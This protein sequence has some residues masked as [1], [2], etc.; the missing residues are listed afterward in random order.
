MAGSGSLEQTPTWAVATVCF[1]LI[2]ISIFIEQIIHMIG[3]WFK[4]KRKKA[5][6]EALEKIKA[7]LMLLGFIS[8]LLTVGTTP[9]TKICISE[10]AASGWHPC[11]RNEDVAADDGGE[12]RRRLL[13]WSKMGNNARRILAGA[14]SGGDDKCAKKGKVSFMSYDGVHQLHIF[15]FALALFHVIYSVLTMALGQAKMRKWKN[16]EKETRTIEYQFSHD[17]ERFRFARDT[18]FGRRHMSFWSKSPILLWIVCFFRQFFRSVPKVDYLT[19]RHGFIMAHLGPQNQ[20]T[21]DFQK[22]I[23][24]SLEND[25][26]TVVGISPPIWLFAIVFLLFNTHGWYSYLW[27]PF[28]PLVVILLIGTKLQVII[29][30]MGLSIQERGEVVQGVPVVQTGDDL[31]WFNRPRLILYLIN[32]VLFQNAFQVAFFAWTWYEFGIKSCFH[33]RTEDV[34]I[35]ITMG[36]LVQILCSYVTLP[37][38]ALV[39]QMGSNMRPTVFNE[40]VATAIRSWHKTAKKQI[41][42]NQKSGQVTPMSSRPG[43]PTH[44]MSPVHLL[45]NYRND[46][47]SSQT[48]PRMSNFDT[49]NWDTD[50][51]PS[52]SYHQRRD[53]ELVTSHHP[54]EQES[55]TIDPNDEISDPGS[56]QMVVVVPEADVDQQHVVTIHVPKEFSFDKRTSI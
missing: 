5:L 32:F 29:T 18:S 36:V 56:S 42:T 3:N 49:D 55:M 17:P 45:R 7:E 11:S 51:S 27:L 48:S 43:T 44:G 1:V 21:F 25:F 47:D 39:T 4:K 13:T 19:L 9:I 37:L 53:T 35:R 15:I 28:I 26:K 8:L 54:T 20:S 30:K 41:K 10:G 46:I 40:R 22:Y 16:W 50:G 52:P 12:S 31:F 34:V 33:E 24:R 14:A 2:A 23:S 6:Y 38:Y